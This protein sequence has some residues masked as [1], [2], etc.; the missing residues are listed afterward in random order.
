M[1]RAERSKLPKTLAKRLEIQ[2]EPVVGSFAGKVV[3]GV[4]AVSDEETLQCFSMR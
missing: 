4:E 3:I 1:G 2:K